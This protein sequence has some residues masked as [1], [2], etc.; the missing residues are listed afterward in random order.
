MRYIT[1]SRQQQV[2]VDDGCETYTEVDSDGYPILNV[3]KQTHEEWPSEKWNFQDNYQPKTLPAQALTT[4]LSAPSG[5][6]CDEEGSLSQQQQSTQDEQLEIAENQLYRFFDEV[7]GIGQKLAD[8]II[9]ALG[10]HGVVN[11]LEHDP[12]ALTQ[13][14]HIKGKKLANIVDHWPQFTKQYRLTANQ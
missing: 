13:V 9:A 7:K 14:K 12:Q 1:F 6:V 10:A 5:L 4:G 11:A 2:M 8:N 3:S